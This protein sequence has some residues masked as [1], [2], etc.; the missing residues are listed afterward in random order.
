MTI[1]PNKPP[2]LN[3]IPN[4]TIPEDTVQ[5]TVHLSGIN[6]DATPIEVRQNLTV[7]ATSGNQSVIRDSDISVTYT[8]PNNTAILTYISVLHATGVATITVKVQDD[9][10]TS[11]NGTDT[12]LQAFNVTVSPDTPPTL[13]PIAN[14]SIPED[15]VL[16][17]VVLTGIFTD[18]VPIETRQIM[19]VTATSDNQA[20]I[21]D[22]DIG[23]VYNNNST[24][25]TLTYISPYCM[26]W[27]RPTSP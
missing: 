10:G 22:S 13:D 1:A 18:A 9:G 23:I 2:T 19:T 5:Q 12:F 27:A 11:G 6:T 24:T 20:V 3:A 14:A 25:A 16:Q 15:N 17:T 4:V 8:S 26:G 7:T 21:Q